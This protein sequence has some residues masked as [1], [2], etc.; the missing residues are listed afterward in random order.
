M[1]VYLVEWACMSCGQTQSFRYIGSEE[2]G[3]PNK[4]EDRKCENE[5]CGQ[6][7]DVRSNTCTFT[8]LTG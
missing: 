5:E 4:F 7:Q 2:D 1:D 8:R 6:V 3:W